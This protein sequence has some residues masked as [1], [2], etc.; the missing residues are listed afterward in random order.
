MHGKPNGF[1]IKDQYSKSP[2]DLVSIRGINPAGRLSDRKGICQNPE[3]ITHY[4]NL[5]TPESFSE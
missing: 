1:L 2:N 5:Y 4:L 3:G